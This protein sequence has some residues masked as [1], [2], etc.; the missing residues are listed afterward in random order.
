MKN[1]KNK[2]LI[3]LFS[4]FIVAA[5]CKKKTDGVITP[6]DRIAFDSAKLETFFKSHPDFKKYEKDINELYNK[7]D[8]HYVWYDK[9]GRVDFAEVLYGKLNEIKEEGVVVKMPYKAELDELFSSKSGDK[10]TLENDLLVSAMYFYYT[11]N[12]LAGVDTKTSKK[13]GWYLP[14]PNVSYVDYLAELMKDPEKL[15]KD[16]AENFSQYYLLKKGLKRYQDI[17]AKGGWG[18]VDFPANVKTLKEGDSA[19]AIAQIRKR[20]FITGDLTNDNGKKVFDSELKDGLAK[21]ETRHN[22][23]VDNIITATLAKELSI[24][25]EDRIKTIIVNMERCRWIDPEIMNSPELVAVNIPSYK[26]N[27]MKD[28]KT[29]LESNVVVGKELNKTVVFSGKMSYIVFS[30]YWNIPKS[31]IEKEIKPGMEKNPN[32]LES[33]NMEWN[34][35]NVRQKPGNANS[36]G[37]VKFMFPNSNNIYLHDT[38]SKSLFNKESRAFSHGCVR[39]EKARDLAIAIMDEQNKMSTSQIDAAMNAGTEQSV[40]LKRKIPVYISYFTAWADKNGNVNFYE[41]VYNRDNRLAQ[42]L[43]TTKK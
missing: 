15:E 24:P 28:G 34:D 43:Y 4:L 40:S 8:F 10:S 2:M 39:V 3:G 14:R 7:E 29:V 19:V 35:G 33:K 9:D 31:I 27:Y 30:P 36:L 1:I 26:L 25:V 18:K 17:Q 20:L 11:N 23:K 13:T 5:S 21:Y 38:P 6:E 37:L 42:L 22:R 32:Y 16:E 12:V 41:D